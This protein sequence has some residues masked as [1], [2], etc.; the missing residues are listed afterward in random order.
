M[1]N[2]QES[3]AQA[4]VTSSRADHIVTNPI[5]PAAST[6][7][8][9]ESTENLVPSNIPT[10]INVSKLEIALEGHP[11]RKLVSQLCSNLSMEPE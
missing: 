6:R 7:P 3:T 1:E 2:T 8:T 10:P 4:P 11:D 5:H 9:Q